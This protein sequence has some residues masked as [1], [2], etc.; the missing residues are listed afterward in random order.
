MFQNHKNVDFSNQYVGIY[1][2]I[3]CRFSNNC[4]KSSIFQ[5]LSKIT[6]RVLFLYILETRSYLRI[7]YVENSYFFLEHRKLNKEIFRIFHENVNL[8]NQHVVMPEFLVNFSK[9]QFFETPIGIF[10]YISSSSYFQLQFFKNSYHFF[11]TANEKYD[12]F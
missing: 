10:L 11:R 1:I 9:A 4:S 3:F 2:F 8:W 12:D 5:E 6:K 7:Y